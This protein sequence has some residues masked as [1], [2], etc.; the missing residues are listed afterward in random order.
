MAELLD[1]DRN[2][3]HGYEVSIGQTENRTAFVEIWARRMENDGLNRLVV[4]A[5]MP[6]REIT[7]LRT[8]MRYLRQVGLHYSREYIE[9]TLA[10]NPKIACAIVRLFKGLF[11]PKGTDNE[12]TAAGCAVEIDH[13]LDDGPS[14]DSIM[15]S[16]GDDDEVDELLL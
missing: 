11:D 13:L 8:Y 2:A 15:D 14:L 1:H 3:R 5:K 10:E 6:W 16:S 9:A 4:A 7:V 12:T